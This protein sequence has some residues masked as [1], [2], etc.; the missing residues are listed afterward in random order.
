MKRKKQ[1]AKKHIGCMKAEIIFKVIQTGHAQTNRYSYYMF[2]HPGTGVV[3]II[4][5][6][7]RN[8][9]GLKG[10]EICARMNTIVTENDH[11]KVLATPRPLLKFSLMD[12]GQTL[13]EVFRNTAD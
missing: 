11:V 13:K 4:R 10:I 6:P 1:R 2:Q 5:I 7:H 12:I 3:M 9:K 8:K